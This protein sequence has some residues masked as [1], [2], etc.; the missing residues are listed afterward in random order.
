MIE[1]IRHCSDCGWDGPFEQFHPEPGSC[2]DAPD[3]NCPEW[4]CTGCGA[5]QFIGLLLVACEPV[6]FEPVELSELSELRGRVA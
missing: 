6:P 2:P 5:G 3:G 4:S 1:M